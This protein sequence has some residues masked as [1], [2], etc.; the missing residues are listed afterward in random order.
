MQLRRIRSSAWTLLAVCT[1]RGDC[2]L[3][4][5]LNRISGDL[6]RDGRRLLALF[7]RVAAQGPPRNAEVSHQLAEGI[8]EFVQGRLRAVWFYDERRLVIVTHGF[9]KR[10]RRTPAAEIERAA[11]LRKAYLRDRRRGKIQI[12]EIGA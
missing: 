3:L 5:F 4:E 7:E 1:D 11:G 6:S 2:P 9:V 10:T 8:W 12:E